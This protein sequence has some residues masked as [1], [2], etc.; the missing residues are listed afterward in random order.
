VTVLLLIAFAAFLLED[1]NLVGFA[2]FQDGGLDIDTLYIGSTDFDLTLVVEEEYFVEFESGTDLGS[3][4][5]DENLLARFDL[6]L[7]SS[8]IYDCVHK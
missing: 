7:L 2:M 3:L 1:D 8:N 5:V 4:A 6:E